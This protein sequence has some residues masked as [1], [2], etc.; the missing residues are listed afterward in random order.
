MTSQVCYMVVGQIVYAH[1]TYRI[2][3]HMKQ[4]GTHTMKRILSLIL[5]AV[6]LVGLFPST[7][8]AGSSPES[9]SL[10]ATELTGLSR[11]DEEKQEPAESQEN[12]GYQPED[13]VT[14]IVT[15]TQEPVLAGFDRSSV[16]G[17]SAGEAVSQYLSGST[18]E[19]RQAQLQQTQSNLLSA[20]GRD[21]KLVSQWTNLVNAMAVEIPYSRLAE[22]QAM[23]GV[24]SAYVQHVYDRPIEETGDLSEE[25]THGYSY[26]LVG[27]NGAWE[28][29]F[30]GKG[31]LVAILDTGLDI[32]WS[33]WGDSA[34]LNTGVRRA[35]QAFRENSFRNDPDDAKDG[36]ELRYT[37][38]SMAR[39]LQSTQLRANTGS[40]GQHITYAHNDP[41]KNRKVP[42]A[43]DYA[44]GDLNVQ[45][46][47]SNHGTH[48]AGTV[49]GYAETSEGEVLF[50]GVAPDAQILAMKVFPDV[51]GG[52]TE[53]SILNALEDTATLGADVVNLSLGSDNGFSHDDSAASVVYKR[54]NDAGIL[55]MTSAGNAGYSS[56]NNNYGGN[57]LTSDPEISMMSSPAIYSTNLAV[58]SMENMVQ[59]RSILTWTGMDGQ[60]HTIAFQDPNEVAM[61]Y[62][63][64]G[65][66]PVNVIPV[67]GYGT[68]EDYSNAGFR[69]Y[70]GSGEKGETGIALVKRGGGIS[71]ADKI[72]VAT[73]FTWSYY[74]SE[75]GT[76]VT[77]SPV[78]A[79]IIYDEDSNSTELIYMSTD[80]TVL[81]SAF[82]SG[83]DGAALAEAAKSAMK[84]G[85]HAT[86]TVEK[87]DEVVS[88]PEGGQM[89]SFSSWG[90]GPGLELKPEI[91]APGGNIWSTIVDNT[92]SP[93][94]PGG[95]YDDYEGSYGMMSGTSMAAPHMTG[96]TA[97]VQEYVQE[98]LGVTARIPMSNLAEHLLV[99]TA[100]PMQDPNG[101]YY[102]PRQQGA[103]LA[104][105]ANAVRTPAYITVQGQSVGK[106]EL[107]DDPEKTGSYHMEFTV[108]NLTD[109][110]LTYNAKAAVLVPGTQE[111]D[112]KYGQRDVML[113][114]DV[115]LR[116]VDLGTV[117]VPAS[118]NTL[119]AKDVAL[120][121]EEKAR[122]DAA[123]ENG[124][125]VEGFVI[126]TDTQGENPQIG[127]PFLA[128]YGDW[129]AAPIFDSA[130]WVDEPADGKDVFHNE[131]EWN[132][133]ILGYYDGYSYTNF[134]QNPFD[135]TSGDTQRIFHPENVTISPTGFFKTVN[136]YILYQKREARVEV[137][138]VKDANTGEV[139]YRDYTAF[140]FKSYYNQ[141]SGMV[142]PASL[143]YFTNSNFAGKDMNGN[144]IPS[145]TQC[146]YTV[147]AYG[148]ADFPMTYLNGQEVVDYDAIASGSWKPEFNGHSMDMT[149]DV[150]AVPMLVDTEAP[151]LENS[152]VSATQRDGKTILSGKFLDDG[153]IASVEVVP[154]VKRTAKSDPTR[155][156]YALDRNNTFYIEQ[157]YDAAVKEWAFEAD[158]SNYEHINQTY[159]G[160]NNIYDFEWTGDVYVFGG[161]YGGNDRAYTVTVDVTPGLAL[162]TTS[163]LLHVG[164]SF[165]LNV[166]NN[167]GSDAPIT[168]TS[169]NPQVATVNEFGHIEALQAGQTVVE[170][171]NGTVSAYCVVAVR[172]KNREVLDFDLSISSFSGMKPNGAIIVKVQ[173]LQPADVELNEIRWEVFEN[174]PELYTG[175]VTC[176]RYTSDGLTGEVYLNY[177]ATGTNNPPVPGA[178]A[179]LKVTLNGVTREMKLDW[180]DLYT[181][182]DDEDLISNLNFNDQTVYVT[183]GESAL[184]HARYNDTSA[185]SVANVALWTG[186]DYNPYDSEHSQEAAKGLILDGPDFCPT[187]GTWEG[188]LVNEEG[189]TLPEQIRVFTRYD[190]GY[191][192]EM[193]NSWRQDFSYDAQ[194]GILKV[195]FTPPAPTSTLVI[196]ADGV[197]SAGYPA[198]TVSG[199]TYQR[200]EA[201]CGPFDWEVISGGGT[202]TTEDDYELNGTQT[203]VA[204]Y[205]PAET[206]CSVI[207]A[208]TKD[209]KYSVNFTVISEPVMP[210]TLE[211]SQS[212]LTLHEGESQTLTTT[213]TPEPTLEKHEELVWKSYDESVAKVDEN[214][215]ITAVAPGFAFITVSSPYVVEAM[216]QCIVEVLPCEHADTET[217][218]IPATCEEDGSVTV[219][220]KACGKVI[221]TEILPKGHTYTTVVTAPTCTEKGYTTYTCSVCG[222]TYVADEVPALG[223]TYTSE[224]VA[225][226]AHVGGYTEHTC[227]VCGYTYRDSFTDPLPCPSARFTDVDI[228]L[229]YHEGV[230]FV[231]ANEFMKGMSDTL[232]QPSGTLTRGQLVTILHRMAGTPEAKAESPFTDVVSS[233][234]FFDAVAWAYEAK[235]AKGISDIAFAPNAPVTREQLVTFLYRYAQYQEADV[236]AQSS[237][238]GYPDAASL[239]SYAQIPM[240]WAVE[241]KLVCGMDGKLNP[242]STATRA[243]IATIIQ[244]YCAI[245]SK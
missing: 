163:A 20:M 61:K 106:L 203:P 227:T 23:D 39:L 48:V 233:Q 182:K 102:S 78:K 229:W 245:Y 242:N 1:M 59:A 235:I 198:G 199:E 177:S 2:K 90:A 34:N 93:A 196:R 206:G 100:L 96:L 7:L 10:R 54:L 169:S 127:L 94:E 69:S 175:L 202:L 125:Y 55:F 28:D 25:G 140:Q 222:D 192:Y 17:V 165:D 101:V 232:F 128:Y 159:E 166:C 181:E 126:L 86:L 37:N 14:V 111:A 15:L 45:P 36:W 195:F 228:S 137:V 160:E 146:V 190:S 74:D 238:T 213:L 79:V 144:P 215:K 118:G 207:Q 201:L 240:A 123:F 183:Q 107:K 76:Y 141:T 82:I 223:H 67:D 212:R 32:T 53:V 156:D 121:T 173:N 205:T 221:S 43:A 161:D 153:A 239:S 5:V 21:V 151:K 178:S 189:Y 124:I 191:E 136:D 209:G 122:L 187:N 31:M 155:V 224:V 30:T 62:K 134:A 63:F 157:I 119:V 64:A 77:E 35:H 133:S 27:L 12:P 22:I 132:V 179:T 138:E 26:D 210:E 218:T 237:L 176:S 88:S 38:E 112:T 145:G 220:C 71:F 52:A 66:D 150:I 184:L 85:S 234:Y 241:Q 180:E 244:R 103:G 51:D 99:S 87:E 104:N 197:A 57:T 19:T 70:Y 110:A 135:G 50:S 83:K 8:A 200:P 18:A 188:K 97:L 49:A 154:M 226:L 170:V 168:T 13:L 152:A 108:R 171:T 115:L 142:L 42:F 105:V 3:L 117:T 230:D 46:T 214:G 68:Y 185:H 129:T 73:Q 172:E 72:N 148:E 243:Q 89:S 194:T 92:Y 204:H 16:S 186:Q 24:Q 41:Y 114:S 225:P 217:V 98:K 236:S 11:L 58:A 149:G 60:A 231:V 211:L 164:S 113:A 193:T 65:R 29:G 4:K 91:T 219:T 56:V 139:Y 130:T 174:D 116:E 84:A 6:M 9:Q 81:T 40:Q 75:R 95:L 47:E 216:A 80:N 208:T 162:S 131:T 147:T 33:S 120:T 167:T 158:V 44:D 109:E 143:Y